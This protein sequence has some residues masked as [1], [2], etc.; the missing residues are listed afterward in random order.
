MR[1]KSYYIVMTSNR[2]S[3]E[4]LSKTHAWQ[5]ASR[6]G[7]KIARVTKKGRINGMLIPGFIIEAWE[8]RPAEFCSIETH[9]W[10]KVA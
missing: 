5:Y 7:T 9:M 6:H 8:R 3:L 1:A 10:F 4:T 2:V